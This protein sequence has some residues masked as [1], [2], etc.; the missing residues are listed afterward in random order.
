MA[1]EIIMFSLRMSGDT[2]RLKSG[3]IDWVHR[4]GLGPTQNQPRSTLG[5]PRE[6]ALKVQA[7]F[8]LSQVPLER[9]AK[10]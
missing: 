7:R 6:F 5:Y 10:N 4:V 8:K 1:L 2:K 3:F 9:A